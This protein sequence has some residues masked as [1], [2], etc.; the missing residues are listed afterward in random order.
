MDKKTLGLGATVA[1]DGDVQITLATNDAA[2]KGNDTDVLQILVEVSAGRVGK[3][4]VENTRT[5]L[6]NSSRKE[7]EKIG[8]AS[9][10]AGG[11]YGFKI[12]DNS[13]PVTANFSTVICM[14]DGTVLSSSCTTSA[15]DSDLSNFTL[16]TG[17]TI[18]APWTHVAVDAGAVLAFYSERP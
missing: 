12:I 9:A 5:I 1:L 16:V 18:A 2:A 14:S 6:E 4:A 13:S 8:Q 7:L 10:Q 3:K 17:T 15:G 11:D